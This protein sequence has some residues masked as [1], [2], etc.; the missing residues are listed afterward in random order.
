MHTEFYPENSVFADYS[1]SGGSSRLRNRVA[2]AMVPPSV[3]M[4]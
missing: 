4:Q 3:Q 1:P 2:V